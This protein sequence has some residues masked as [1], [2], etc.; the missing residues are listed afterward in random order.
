[1]SSV[2]LSQLDGFKCLWLLS[3]LLIFFVVKFSDKYFLNILV[4][5]VLQDDELMGDNPVSYFLLLGRIK[6]IGV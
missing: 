5:G 3:I 6:L 1:M 2:A 4:T